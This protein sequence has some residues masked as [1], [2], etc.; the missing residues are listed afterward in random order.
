MVAVSTPA[1]VLLQQ[2]IVDST[3]P[4]RALTILKHDITI[5]TL[6]WLAI[7]KLLSLQSLATLGTRNVLPPRFAA[8]ATN[9][10]TYIQL[11]DMEFWIL[12][13]SADGEGKLFSTAFALE[14][15]ITLI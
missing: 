11:I 15:V 8:R 12:A 10:V 3:A 1:D 14:D 9:P 7:A 6:V 13:A 5:F 2:V 4:I